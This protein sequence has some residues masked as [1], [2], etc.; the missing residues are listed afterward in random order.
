MKKN[1]D[2][3][4]SLFFSVAFLLYCFEGLWGRAEH[5]LCAAIALPS[6]GV[7]VYCMLFGRLYRNWDTRL[8]LAFLGLAWLSA[9]VNYGLS[10]TF[11]FSRF[12]CVW[13]FLLCGY[14]SVQTVAAPERFLLGCSHAGVAGLSIV[15]VFAL[16]HATVS[17]TAAV[18][19][20]DTVRG[21]FELGRL[22]AL[23][24]ANILGFACCTLLLL[25]LYAALRTGGKRRL[26][27]LL[28]ALLGWFN[29]G[30]TNFRTGILCVSLAVGGLVFSLLYRKQRP[31]LASAALAVLAAGGAAASLY[32]P[33]PLYRGVLGLFPGKFRLTAQSFLP[34]MLSD[35]A[36]FLDR[37]R[38]WCVTLREIFRTPRR[39]WLGVSSIGESPIAGV[40]PGHHEI[41]T[42]HAHNV[43][44]EI[45]RRFGV[46]ALLLLLAL[47]VLW[48]IRGARRFF[49]RKT[50]SAAA[51]L[52]AIAAVTLLTGL[53]EQLPFPIG[54]AHCL[55]IPFFLIC[56]YAA[57]TGR[58]LS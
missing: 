17:L 42:S 32:L 37:T 36:T 11:F 24:N 26:V 6:L 3:A 56:G 7:C 44:L 45:L 4:L 1:T 55:S 31:F 2:L 27:F 46:F 33:L 9:L 49:D 23:S 54:K 29:L 30:L 16:L 50:S 57:R 58:K 22:C 21:C 28:P 10:L 5:L 51:F 47:L 19:G 18:P 15:N 41:L 20:R 12:F 48:C 39:T 35:S 34:R 38:I 14:F 53:V 40:Y 25:S 8:L 13:V 52:M 43:Y